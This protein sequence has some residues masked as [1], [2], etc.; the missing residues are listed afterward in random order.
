MAYREKGNGGYS[1]RG[2]KKDGKQGFKKMSGF[3]RRKICK[4]CS[5]KDIELNYKNYTV[6]SGYITE[7]GKIVPRR[8]SGTCAKCQRLLAREIKRAR[9]MALIP[10]T[11][12]LFE[13]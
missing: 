1:S 4:F 13:R 11:S 12:G 10:Y 6:L 9:Q 2:D 8:I 5:D 7:K 3:G